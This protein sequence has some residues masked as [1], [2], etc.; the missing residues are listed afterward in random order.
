M[1]SRL[2]QIII[3]VIIIIIIIIIIIVM[4]MKS[5]PKTLLNFDQK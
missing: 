4:L 5:F 3:I 2:T 1:T